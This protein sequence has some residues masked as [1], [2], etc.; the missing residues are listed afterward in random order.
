MLHFGWP[1]YWSCKF[2]RYLGLYFTG[3][4][5]NI[6]K[7]INPPYFGEFQTKLFSSLF[8][9]SSITFAVGYVRHYIQ[10]IETG[11]FTR[12]EIESKSDI[13]SRWV[14]KE[15]NLMF[16]L[17]RDKD[18]RKLFALSFAFLGVN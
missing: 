16:I 10:F 5:I 18:Q 8:K 11:S 9:T 2:K 12:S 3:Y 13:A 14:Y 6:V 15:C 1:L 7:L 17:R 4:W